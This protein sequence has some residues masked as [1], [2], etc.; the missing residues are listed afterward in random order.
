MRP[1]DKLASLLKTLL[2]LLV[3]LLLFS[4]QDVSAPDGPPRIVSAASEDWGGQVSAATGITVNTR[5]PTIRIIEPSTGSTQTSS[6]IRVDILY[7]DAVSGIDLSSLNVLL[8]G[9]AVTSDLAKTLREALGILYN[10]PNGVHTLSAS[11]ADNA[12]NS[13]IT[14][15][16][17]TVAPAILLSRLN[18]T[19]GSVCQSVVLSGSGF[20]PIISGN[21]IYFHGVKARIITA[22]TTSLTALVPTGATSGL[23]NVVV[24]N[25][26]SNGLPFINELYCPPHS[27]AAQA[28]PSPP[29]E[30]HAQHKEDFLL[31]D[32][33]AQGLMPV[34][35]FCRGE[36]YAINSGWEVILSK[37]CKDTRRL[38]VTCPPKTDPHDKLV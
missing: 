32:N 31:G 34:G 29:P 6:S 35:L 13:T 38:V 16:T 12:G 3:G 8:D 22:S 11:I 23:V 5:K 15:A 25:S 10:V 28:S 7:D 37:R 33:Y 36:D 9:I 30:H 20:D 24:G 14:T 2:S 21:S 27:R 4:S 18:P 19:K 17:F 26:V 1:L